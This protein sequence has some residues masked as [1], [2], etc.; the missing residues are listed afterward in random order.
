LEYRQLTRDDRV[1]W[2][3]DE[4]VLVR[5]DTG[6]PLHW[7]GVMFDVTET[8]RI[9]QQL[10]ESEARFAAFMGHS[11]ALAWMKDEGLRYVYV[12]DTYERALFHTREEIIG[13]DDFALW[14]SET[15]I[16]MRETDRVVLDTGKAIETYE[17]IPTVDGQLVTFLVLKFPFQDSAGRRFVGSMGVDV[18]E[19]LRAEADLHEQYRA[20]ERARGEADAIL[21]ATNEAI[22]LVTPERQVATINRRSEEVLG[23]QKDGVIN[24]PLT[25]IIPQLHQIFDDPSRLVELLNSDEVEPSLPRRSEILQQQWPEPRELELS[26]APVISAF[27]EPLGRLF[28][29]RDVTRE[30][31]VDRMKTEFVSL[32]S[33]ELRTPLT[34]ITGYVDLMLE[35]EVGELSQE[36][37]EFLEIVG[38]NAQRLVALIND[39]LDISRIE[40]GRLGLKLR[41]VDLSRLVYGVVASFRPLMESKRQRLMIS[42]PEYLPTIMGDQ[43]RVTQILTNL[44]SNA[45]KY[46]PAGGAI[47]VAAERQ[48][49][50]IRIDLQDT[51]I[52]MTPEEQAQLF[53]RFFR[54]SNRTTQEVGGTGLGLVITRSL[55]EM[56]RGTIEVVSAAGRG[57]TFSFTLPIA[58]VMSSELAPDTQNSS[59]PVTGTGTILVVEDE[60][61]IANLIRRYL[62]RAGYDVLL[63]TTAAEARRLARGEN[64][65]LI[66]L[67]IMLPDANGL[68]LLEWLKAEEATRLIPV[69]A[70]SMLADDNRA[71]L[72]GAV[73]YLTKPV[74]ERSLVDRV[75]T[76]LA[77]GRSRLVVVADHDGDTR[78]MIASQLRRF[79]CSVVEAADA[80]EAITLV[81]KHK[82]A[83][84]IIDEQPGGINGVSAVQELREEPM[85]H[86]LPIIV[87][88]GDGTTGDQV[89]SALVGMGATTVLTKP[90]LVSDLIASLLIGLPD[91]NSGESS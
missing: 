58:G 15:A 14:P 61:D 79:G 28:A 47:R 89:E 86:N 23:I 20:A 38:N 68:T 8:R 26:T 64:P 5:D 53:T 11:P 24:A 45:H 82:P 50:Q 48:G 63:A 83:L 76:I 51:G 78:A 67:D 46:T 90:F 4:A 39:L 49:R 37:R 54:A 33:H 25:A 3:R 65:D 80:D 41:P 19:R 12:N 22:L 18:T 31:L 59:E 91:A 60:P 30:R 70:L 62:E 21:D 77:A 13:R 10:V 84:L 44:L 29:F 66:T 73:D 36:Q 34:S 42:L 6:R 9:E 88:A 17:T 81:L 35:G 55:V 69:L 75:A 27:G 32:V 1:V 71:K 56:H 52:G 43:D 87:M 40:S 7:Q 85:T 57:S 74:H 72:L 2:L 16:F